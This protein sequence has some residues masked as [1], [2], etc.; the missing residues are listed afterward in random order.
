MAMSEERKHEIAYRILKVQI[1]KNG[2]RYFSTGRDIGNLV[3][4]HIKVSEDELWE[5]GETVSAE[6]HEETFGERSN[7]RASAETSRL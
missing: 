3:K 5:F 7:K 1:S 4:E 6:L 2:I